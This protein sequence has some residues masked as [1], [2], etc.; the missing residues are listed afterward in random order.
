MS[1][2]GNG[3]E[4]PHYRARILEIR[5]ETPRIKSFTLDC[6]DAPFAFHAGQW[7]DLFAQV[8]GETRVGGYSMTS[9]PAEAPRFQLAVQYS[10]RHAVTRWLHEEARVGDEVTV[11]AGQGPFFY[12]PAMGRELVLLGAGIGVTPLVSIF[13]HAAQVAPEARVLLVH[14]VAESAELL[15]RE[16][17][18][19][20]AVDRAGFDYVPTVTG[21]E[22]GWGGERGR[23]DAV[24]LDRLGAT[25]RA[26][27]YFCGARDFIETMHTLLTGHGVPEA[28][29]VFEKWW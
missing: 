26:R 22:Q 2:H 24:L 17:L 9:A 28:Q 12:E 5:Q 25:P 14:S 21:G 19:A 27:Y 4:V 6:G 7:V 1:T 8:D 11:S 3:A 15:F 29:Q 18:R 16:E 23:I 20:V 13:R 10:P